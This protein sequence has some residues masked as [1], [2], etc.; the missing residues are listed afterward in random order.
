MSD[1]IEIDLKSGLFTDYAHQIRVRAEFD[2]V[3]MLIR[4]KVVKMRT[5]AAHKAG[6][7]LAKKAGEALPGEFVIMNINGEA[8][9]LPPESALN[10]GG[11]LLRK[12]DDVDDYQLRKS[13]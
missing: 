3:L 7:A 8:F 5:T 9:E 12:A 13:T 4:R 2:H 10:L 6:F 1:R 11:A